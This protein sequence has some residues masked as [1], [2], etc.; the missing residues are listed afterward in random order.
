MSQ[1]ALVLFDW[2]WFDKTVL[3]LHHRCCCCALAAF[4]RL[5]R[6]LLL[7][8]LPLCANLS[9]VVFIFFSGAFAASYVKSLRARGGGLRP[10]KVVEN[11]GE[12]VVIFDPSEPRK[13]GSSFAGLF[14]ET[15]GGW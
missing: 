10:F 8:P 2:Y 14:R 6:L 5:G 7:Y 15:G 1:N 3:V 11:R 4:T 13:D 12:A 9:G